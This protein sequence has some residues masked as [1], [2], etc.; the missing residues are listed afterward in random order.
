MAKKVIKLVLRNCS[1]L[2][3]TA[4]TFHIRKLHPDTDHIEFGNILCKDKDG[5][6][7]RTISLARYDEAFMAKRSIKIFDV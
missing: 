3:I 6:T 5:N 4:K 7:L 1:E 2:P